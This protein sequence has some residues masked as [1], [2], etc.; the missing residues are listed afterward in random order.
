MTRDE[1]I[2]EIE[3]WLNVDDSLFEEE[4]S[5]MRWLLTELRAADAEIKALKFNLKQKEGEIGRA[6]HRGNTVD[7]IYDKLE[8][9]SRQLGEIGPKLT[10][11]TAR[12]H[13][14]VEKLRVANGCL[15]SFAEQKTVDEIMESGEE[16][17]GELD[18]AYDIMIGVAREALRKMEE[19]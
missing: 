19:E 14:A 15:N 17:D 8:N 5:I 18:D 1:R 3:H 13:A 4:T 11:M 7:Y 16:I 12:H 9:Y 6:E 2:A 10:E